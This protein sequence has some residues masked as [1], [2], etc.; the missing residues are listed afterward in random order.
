MVS[1]TFNLKRVHQS[2][3]FCLYQEVERSAMEIEAKYTILDPQTYTSLAELRQIAGFPVEDG[4][5]CIIFDTYQDTSKHDLLAA[6]YACRRRRENDNT[7]LTLKGRRTASPVLGAIHR[8]TELEIPITEGVRLY[9][10]QWPESQLRDL[11][12]TVVQERELVDI[13]DIEQMRR[14]RYLMSA[15]GD[16]IAEMSLD[17]V[18]VHSKDKTHTFTELEIEVLK[19]G[20]ETALEQI[21][22]HMLELKGLTF[23]PVSKFER[24][25]AFATFSASR[26]IPSPEIHTD[27]TLT[28]MAHAVLRPL[29]L[30]LL[31]HEQATYL[32]HEPE[33]LH[34]MRVATRRMRTFLRVMAPYVD[35]QAL[36]PVIKGLRQ[37]ARVLGAVR[38]MDVFRE[39]ATRYQAEAG[40]PDDALSL[41]YQTWNIEYTR[42]RNQLLTYLASSKY[43]EFKQVFW[44]FLEST[45]PGT[46]SRFNVPSVVQQVISG[47]IQHLQDSA[48][49]M[50]QSTSDYAAYHQ[51]RI[52]LKHLRYTLEFFRRLLGPEAGTA[53]EAIKKLQDCF[54]DL[55]DAVVAVHHLH[56]LTSHGTWEI[57]QQLQSLWLTGTVIPPDAV[58]M[59]AVRT[60]L[61]MRKAELE[62]LS[63]SAAHA[64]LEFLESGV[65][66]ATAA[67]MRATDT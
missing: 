4:E 29:F 25:L 40:L 42:V 41:L 33:A 26:K 20:S 14:V 32:G 6:G 48:V 18:K 12:L 35:I 13:L 2:E 9:P 8:R 27:D 58:A 31:L 22:A 44:G 67:E 11:V 53:I 28:Q 52:V 37:T 51:T 62:A 61:Q 63:V 49:A 3:S 38:D 57:P 16:R 7:Y 56:A 66:D 43:S 15:H 46:A 23:Q 39:K 55:Q 45:I 59:D 24:G 19:A 5:T 60:Y 1:E 36:E 65:L 21:I 34:D 50:E 17:D 64:W 47:Q 10:D 30:K 54:G